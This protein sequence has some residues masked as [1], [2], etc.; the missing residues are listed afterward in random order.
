V[1]GRGLLQALVL[2]RP[3]AAAVTAAALDEALVVNDVAPDAIRLAPPLLIDEADL[4][5]LEARLGRALAAASDVPGRA[6]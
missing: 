3:V 1:R 5:E 6:S 4:G 2:D